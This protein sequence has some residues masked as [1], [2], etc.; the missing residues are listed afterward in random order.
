MIPFDG[1]Q[2]TFKQSPPNRLRSMSA[3]FAPKPGGAR[4]AHQ[5]RGAAANDDQIIFFRR[6]RIDPARWMAILNQLLVVRIIDRHHLVKRRRLMVLIDVRLADDA[7]LL[8]GLLGLAQR[9]ARHARNDHDQQDGRRQAHIFQNLL[10]E[11]G[12]CVGCTASASRAAAP[13]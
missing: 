10:I 1:T 2:P 11:I 9:F 5:A 7:A 3:T 13:M 4:R 12:G 6:R 8:L